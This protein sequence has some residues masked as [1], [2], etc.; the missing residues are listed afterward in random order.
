MKIVI[1][2]GGTAGWLS[3]IYMCRFNNIK[4]EI[5]VIESSKIPTIGAGEGSTGILSVLLNNHF[6]KLGINEIDFLN[7]TQSTLKLGVRFRDWNGVGT[8]YLSPLQP[9]DT[10]M[11]SLD[12]DFLISYLKGNYYDSSS[13][14]Y[15]M[16]N[17]YSTYNLNKKGN[18]GGHGFHFDAHKVGEYFKSIA[19]KNGV[20]VIDAEVEH[21]NRNAVTGE[22]ESLDTTIGKID[23]DFWMDCTGFARALITPMGGGWHSYSEY[24]LA[25][26]AI[27]YIHQFEKDEVVKMETLSW[28]QQN[29]WMWQIPTQER[30]G[31]GY[32]YSDMFTTYDN[33]VDELI[34]RTGR[35][36]EPLR[37]I[38]FECGRMDK[39]WVKNVV[40]IGLSSGFLEPLEATSIHTTITQLDL[41][42]TQGLNFNTE[43]IDINIES[44]RSIY[45]KFFRKMF[46]DMADLMQIHY[47]TDREDSEFWKYCKYGLKK[48][49][50]VKE[51]LEICKHRSPSANDY[52]IYHGAS[53][54]GVWCWLLTGL[55][56]LTKEVA[57]KTLKS[58]NHSD[59]SIQKRFEQ[60]K[61]RNLV[62]SI[63]LLKY[64]D[65]MKALK[66]K[67]LK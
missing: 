55:G 21:L 9:P 18:I 59:E 31:C 17:D 53:N 60:L 27:P 28:A 64:K 44:N 35:K 13:S 50:K 25:N 6:T 12:T 19:I 40:A 65:F 10:S 36:I 62:N 4:K 58:Y 7:A 34:K 43:L 38:K 14:G 24:L 39:F 49:D 22:L 42:M 23:G 29:G 3:A 56:H 1:V 52:S 8:E 47:M 15:L 63:K 41:L 26:R 2:G 11:N 67:E 37:N 16:A 66:N 54:W 61:H 30:Y 20:K 33:A 45:N 51:I 46:D 32:V 57:D 5:I 48:T